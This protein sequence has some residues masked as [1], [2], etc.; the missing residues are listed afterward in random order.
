MTTTRFATIKS[1]THADND[2]QQGRVLSSLLQ[3]LLLFGHSSLT[4]WL[5]NQKESVK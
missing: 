3:D 5:I 1:C 2:M 4:N